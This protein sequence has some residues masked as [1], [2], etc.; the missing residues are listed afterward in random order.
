MK[1]RPRDQVPVQ[2][3]ISPRQQGYRN[4]RLYFEIVFTT[5]SRTHGSVLLGAD[6]ISELDQL[7]SRLVAP[8]AVR[9]KRSAHCT[10][11]PDACSVSVEM[12]VLVN[13]RPRTIDWG[14]VLASVVNSPSHVEILRSSS[15]QLRR[16][17][18]DPRVPNTL[19]MPLLP[20]DQITWN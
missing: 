14:S 19:R 11:F 5:N 17:E 3:L 18:I 15:G 13:G 6:S 1:G 4:Y 2:Q 16:L 7:A 20:G 12:S 10:V 9:N 8:E